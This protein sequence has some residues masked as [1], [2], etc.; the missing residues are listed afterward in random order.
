MEI[1]SK[2]ENVDN[3]ITETI[4]FVKETLKN[5]ESGHDWHH[6]ERV[7]KNSLLI[8]NGEKDCS[9]GK[10]LNLMVIQLGA[11]LHDIADHKFHNGDDTKGAKVSSEFLL[12]LGVD[13][14][15]INAVSNIILKISFKGSSSENQMDSTEGKIVQDADRLDA[16]GAIGVA[17]AFSY[18]GYRDRQM[19]DPEDK[20]KLEMNWEEY[21]KNTGCTIN[22]FYEKLLLIKDRM[23]TASGKEIAEKRHVYMVGFLNEFFN[24][25]N[26][27]A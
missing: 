8:Y 7:W 1:N 3:I 16:I 24:E 13:K 2:L 22:H 17:R 25:W 23:N 18:G 15:I 12:G 26:G 20:P 4:K 21:K 5:A 10:D 6:I 11:L 19:Y 9:S 27:L 14:E